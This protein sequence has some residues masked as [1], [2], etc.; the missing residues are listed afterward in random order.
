VKVFFKDVFD[1]HE[2]IFAELGVDVRNG[3][4]D[5]LEK[6]TKLDA[7]KKAEIEKDIEDCFKKQPPW[8]WWILTGASRT[9][10]CRVISS[11]T[12]PCLQ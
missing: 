6:I 1:K 4:G 2:A 12:I 10:M 9:C 11:L 5:V 3:F 8:Q 7:E